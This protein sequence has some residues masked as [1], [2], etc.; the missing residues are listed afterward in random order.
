MYPVVLPVEDDVGV[1][2]GEVVC[3]E[4]DVLDPWPLILL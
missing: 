2:E 1:E 4:R 3:L